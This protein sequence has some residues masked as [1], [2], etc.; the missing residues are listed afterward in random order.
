MATTM[1]KEVLTAIELNVE[2]EGYVLH[3]ERN[4]NNVGI[5]R[6]V[7]EG[8][9]TSQYPMYFDFQNQYCTFKY[10]PEYREQPVRHQ[11][12]IMLT[13]SKGEGEFTTKLQQVIDFLTKG[14]PR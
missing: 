4:L 9:F 3:L 2:A 11:F 10:Q 14:T 1:Q 8:S 12:T 5:M 13:Y 7:P 6:A